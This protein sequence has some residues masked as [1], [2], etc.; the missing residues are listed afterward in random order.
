MNRPRPPIKISP[1][2]TLIGFPPDPNEPLHIPSSLPNRPFFPHRQNRTLSSYQPRDNISTFEYDYP[3]KHILIDGNIPSSI[4]NKI[5][6][7]V[8][9]DSFGT[10]PYSYNPQSQR[11]ARRLTG[12]SRQYGIRHIREI[13]DQNSY[14]QQQIN[15]TPQVNCSFQYHLNSFPMPIHHFTASALPNDPMRCY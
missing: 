14:P 2:S 3:I 1:N 7:A 6:K 4:T 13:H 10:Q 12:N 15:N 11:N 8:E 9:Y 5:N